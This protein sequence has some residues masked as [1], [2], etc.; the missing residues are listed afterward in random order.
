MLQ[1]NYNLQEYA[2]T[3]VYEVLQVCDEA[4][5]GHPILVSE[6]GRALTAHH[7]MVV[8]PVIDAIG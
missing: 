2:D 5:V 4:E 7:A 3:V 1:T 6:S 8:L